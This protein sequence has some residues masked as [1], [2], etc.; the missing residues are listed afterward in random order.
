MQNLSIVSLA[1]FLLLPGCV[2]GD[3]GNM[4]ADFYVSTEGNDAW[5]GKLAERNAAGNDGPFVTLER[6]RR[7]VCELRRARPALNRPVTVAVRGGFYSL[8]KP[9]TLTPDDSGTAE[10]P[11]VFAAYGDERPVI[12][13]GTV[14]AGWKIEENGWW[15]VEL[16][17]VRAGKWNVSQ[18]FVNGR[19]RFRPRLPRDGYFRIDKSVPASPKAEGKGFDRFG[20]K[21]GDLSPGWHNLGDVEVMVFH[22]WHSSTFHIRELDEE[23]GVVTLAGRT[24][25]ATGTRALSQGVRYVLANVREALGQPGDW[26]LDRTNGVLTYVPVPG[27]KPEDVRVVAPRLEKIL[28]LAGDIKQKRWVEHIQFRGLT[29]AHTN[30]N[31]PADGFSCPQAEVWLPAAVEAT[32]ARNCVLDGCS[33]EHTGGYAVEL[34]IGCRDNRVLNCEMTDLGGGGLKIGSTDAR[35][36]KGP[37]PVP[38]NDETAASN[39]F[40]SNCLIAQGGRLHP[41]AVGVWIGQSH[42]NRVE[43]CE[44]AD[45]YYSGFSVG[46]TWGYGP[47]FAHHNEIRHNHI[48]H[49]GQHVLSDLGGVYT[50][51]IQPG[52]VVAD[53]LIH[54][55]QYY[56]YGGWGLYTDEG[57]SEIVMEDNIVHNTRSGS[58]HQHY[59]KDNVIRNNIFAFGEDSQIER[60][61]TEEHRSFTFTRN[62]VYWKTAPLL[63]GRW[64][65][66]NYDIDGNLYWNAAG[67]PVRFG[68][69]DLAEWRKLGK[70]GRSII[71]DPLFVDADKYDFRLR[72][73]SPA[74]RI[75]F[76]PIDV[77]DAGRLKGW[78]RYADLPAV[79]PAFEAGSPDDAP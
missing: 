49:I 34:A 77:S 59:G 43:H 41:G 74:D 38:L 60:S 56:H 33:V 15:Q 67:G 14:L 48:H 9:L 79:P 2:S 5:S 47:S 58:F 20:F 22:Y 69:L 10:S 39:N 18:L 54:D 71:A 52:T 24:V 72:P 46:W 17:E 31:L 16:P 73:G 64:D 61:R 30:W 4:K 32:G 13:G 68:H 75:G 42:H 57:S 53:N 78:R 37:A 8:D 23:D 63:K 12:S 29:F 1:V 25:R 55:V 26:Y 44:V 66:G 27:E 62:I 76:K 50:L 6:A 65:D 36:L 11:T 3:G 28:V 40:V 51:G 70:D 45:F 21:P 35:W 19:R 7:A